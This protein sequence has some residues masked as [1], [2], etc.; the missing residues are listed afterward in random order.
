MVIALAFFERTI[1]FDGISL[2]RISTSRP[3][4]RKEQP[5]RSAS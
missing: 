5:S 1:F 4:Q 2:R 3:L